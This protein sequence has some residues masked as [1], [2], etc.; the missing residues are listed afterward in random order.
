M[1]SDAIQYF[2]IIGCSLVFY[3]KLSG[4]MKPSKK[5][6]AATAVH[7]LIYAALTL[8]LKTIRLPLVMA[9]LFLGVYVY[10]FALCR[11]PV[12]LSVTSAIV[13][14]SVGFE[15]YTL[16][17]FVC[18]PIL[19]LFYKAIP[20]LFLRDILTVV[21]LFCVELLI[22]IAV[23]RMKRFRKNTS[24]DA[25]FTDKPAVIVGVI[26][27]FI[28]AVFYTRGDSWGM[29]G[30]IALA[31]L[32]IVTGSE[33]VSMLKGITTRVYL[34]KLGRRERDTLEQ[35][36][37]EKNESI[38]RLSAENEALTQMIKRDSEI[39]P[40]MEAA[41]REMLECET[42]EEQARR[43]EELL[44]KI[45]EMAARRNGMVKAH[46]ET[47]KKLPRTNIVSIDA[48]LDYLNAKARSMGVSFD[49]T[50]LADVTKLIGDDGVSETDF[51]TLLLDQGE[52]ALIAASYEEKRNVLAVIG[53][54]DNCPV[55]SVFDSGGSFDKT[56]LKAMG[57]KRVTTHEDSGG[58]GIGLMTT[59]ELLKKYGASF[60]IDEN[61]KSDAYT[62]KTEI[63]FDGKGRIDISV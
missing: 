13:S 15:L 52:N 47:I 40:V 32:L 19:Y 6:I 57:K 14:L 1:L 3:L 48:S 29:L 62:K 16:S 56:V 20:D 31:M 25:I 21:L 45:R 23:L 60:T 50:V 9:A 58:S 24:L 51:N 37:R 8:L 39:L 38:E 33:L 42:P 36:L 61:I 7:T 54:Q 11:K 10:I 46:D 30:I 5:Q 22:L 17:F 12:K 53:V 55:L 43:S 4:E 41:M 2:S 18:T 44:E 35:T 63:R 28:A 49:A 27:I 59:F 26:V 34:K